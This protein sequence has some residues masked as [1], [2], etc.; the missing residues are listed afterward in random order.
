L[1]PIHGA[2]YFWDA[3]SWAQA[4]S[5]G[6]LHALD[7][8]DS[9]Q[10]TDL[11]IAVHRPTSGSQMEQGFV[12]ARSGRTGALL[13][14]FQGKSDATAKA[15]PL[16]GSY[17]VHGIAVIHDVDHD[18]V[19]DIYC[20]EAYFKT[21]A[22]LISGR[23]GQWIGRFAIDRRDFWAEPIRTQDF[24]GD[25]V[26]DFLFRGASRSPLGIEIR[27]GKDLVVLAAHDSIWTAADTSGSGW[28][29]PLLHD[30]DRDGIP[31]CLVRREL[32]RDSR[33]ARYTYE[34]AVLSG[35][36]FSVLTRFVSERPRVTAD[37]CFAACGD[38]NGD[39]R[40]DFAFTSSAG[41]GPDGYTSL[42]RA[43]SAANGAVLW[44]VAGDQ[45]IGGRPGF[46][47]DAKTRKKSDLAPDV[48][49]ESPLVAVPDRN[50]DRVDEL[51]TV[52]LA[53][54]QHGPVPSVYVLS[55]RDGAPL[56][57]LQIDKGSGRLPTGR[58]QIAVLPRATADGTPG[59]AVTA[60][61][62]NGEAMIAVFALR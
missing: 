25:G 57:V 13:W 34:Y 10:V 43:V 59:V 45:L 24:D 15:D 7:D 36:D 49:F 32:E 53:A 56:S 51:V 27:S 38:L 61:A 35:R 11:V 2:D 31:E 50:G 60:S 58:T 12:E 23:N 54:G 46:A 22:I 26:S 39:G 40:D 48:D 18:D 4:I 30:I 8:L 62:T 3:E 33:G 52:A 20:R 16:H 9:D 29:L 28:V 44:Q 6:G 5:C 21:S 42:V 1:I 55:G 47:I 19:R 14:Q 17:A 41:A 37:T